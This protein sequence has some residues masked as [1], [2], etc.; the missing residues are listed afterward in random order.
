V[1]ARPP[2]PGARPDDLGLAR[3]QEQDPGRHADLGLPRGARAEGELAPEARDHRREF[4]R[5]A[6]AV[7]ERLQ[8]LVLG[9]GDPALGSRGDALVTEHRRE[10]P[11]FSGG[12]GASARHVHRTG[13]RARDREQRSAH[14]EHP[15]QRPV[16]V[17]RALEVGRLE[18]GDPGPGGQEHR[19]RVA[20]VQPREVARDGGG[21]GPGAGQ[22]VAHAQPGSALDVGHRPHGLQR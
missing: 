22:V 19:G 5:R 4:G 11:A 18:P 12:Q 8:H 10:A 17:Q 1:P 3:Q 21:I 2:A 6:F 13:E 9:L 16:V 7:D 14:H 15:Q 20:R